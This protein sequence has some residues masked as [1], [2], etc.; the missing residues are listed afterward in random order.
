MEE[1]TKT[2]LKDMSRLTGRP[3]TREEFGVIIS[4]LSRRSSEN[5]GSEDKENKNK[6]NENKETENKEKGK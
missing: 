6:G 1:I 5:E 3:Y 4:D 2:F